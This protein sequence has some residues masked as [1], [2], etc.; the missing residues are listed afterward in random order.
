MTKAN[1]P[2]KSARPS[3]A[4]NIL[5]DAATLTSGTFSSYAQS[6]L[7]L[8]KQCN[9]VIDDAAR[10]ELPASFQQA[11]ATI[12]NGM[13]GS[14]LGADIL[15]SVFSDRMKTPFTLTHD[16]T[17]PSI[18]GPQ[19]LFIAC[20]YSGGTEETV[21]S[22]EHAVQRQAKVVAIASGGKLVAAAR[23]HNAPVFQFEPRFN[24]SGQPR[25]GLGYTLTALWAVLGKADVLP[26]GSH[27]TGQFSAALAA[28][29]AQFGFEVPAEKNPAKLLAQEMHGRQILVI[30]APQLTGH[31]HTFANQCNESAKHYVTYATLPEL[32]HHLLEGLV[33]PPKLA[34]QMLVVFLTSPMYPPRIQKR[35]GIT[36]EVFEKQ[37]FPTFQYD[38]ASSDPFALTGEM[39]QF[40]SYTSFYLAALNHVADPNA[41]PWVD[42][43]KAQL[44]KGN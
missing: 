27:D 5:D 39:L 44:A 42:Y 28:A 7:N 32:N 33:N 13:G 20:S 35:F 12:I 36:R 38:A 2:A 17:V 29:Q 24:P 21:A 1:R 37:G 3:V 43:F 34:K 4:K 15:Q 41:I 6:I 23:Q 22:L 10:F 11:H 16:Y 31:A 40:G 19:T 9:Q 14:G 30:A 26:F 8:S 25:L 18:V